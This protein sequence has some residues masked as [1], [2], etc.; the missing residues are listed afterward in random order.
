MHKLDPF[1]AVGTMFH[2]GETV[3]VSGMYRFAYHTDGTRC[4]NPFAKFR[5]NRAKGKAFPSHHR[6]K[7]P[8]IWRLEGYTTKTPDG[9]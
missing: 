3:P 9:R 5:I 6:C 4:L 8:A 1:T 7:K 2:T